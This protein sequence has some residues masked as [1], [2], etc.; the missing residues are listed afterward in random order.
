MIYFTSDTHF[1]HENIIRYCNRPFKSLKEMDSTIIKNWNSKIKEEDTIFFLGDFCFRKS[2]EAPEGKLF[3]HY[4]SQL[5]GQIIFVQGNH[6]KNNGNKSIIQKIGIAY[7]GRKINLVH[8]P[9]FI[10]LRYDINFVGH[11]HNLWRFKRI[12]R[13]NHIVDCINIGV[14]VWDFKPVT[15]NEI[16]SKYIRWSKNES[17]S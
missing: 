8:N 4:K 11:V 17:I 7:G 10:D 9:E 6:D 1:G 16:M 15:I 12:R 13:D 5:K 14:D 2:S 3:E